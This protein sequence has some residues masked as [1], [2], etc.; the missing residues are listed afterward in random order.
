MPACLPSEGNII[1]ELV[2]SVQVSCSLS[3]RSSG[4]LKI[5][6]KGINHVK[7]TVYSE[8]NIIQEHS[9]FSRNM[10]SQYA[11]GNREKRSTWYY[12]LGHCKEEASSWYKNRESPCHWNKLQTISHFSFAQPTFYQEPT[13]CCYCSR[14]WRYNLEKWRSLAS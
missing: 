10:T 13:M 11:P 3:S 9:L 14:C 7:K 8:L 2:C 4:T 12:C 5:K 1:E 6:T